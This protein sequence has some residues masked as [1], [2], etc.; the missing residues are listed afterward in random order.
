MISICP[1]D[2]PPG[3]SKQQ[4]AYLRNGSSLFIAA[5]TNI[6]QYLKLCVSVLKLIVSY[7]FLLQPDF[8]CMVD[9]FY[10]ETD[11]KDYRG[12]KASSL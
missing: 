3:V 1:V 9:L 4:E 2:P 8:T 6:K 12:L 7:I 10:I 11:L 5:L